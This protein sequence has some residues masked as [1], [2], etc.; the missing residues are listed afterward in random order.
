MGR[1]AKTKRNLRILEKSTA[2]GLRRAK[3][4][5]PHGPSVTP[6]PDT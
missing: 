3:Q 4:E 5:E 2:A 6:P 1:S